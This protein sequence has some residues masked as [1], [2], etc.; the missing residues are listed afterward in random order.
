MKRIMTK[1][2]VPGMVIAE[3]VYSINNNQLI[4]EKGT[5]LSDKAIAK[6]GY[7][8][9]INVFVEDDSQKEGSLHEKESTTL[10]YSQRLR[11]T[12]EFKKFKEDV[13]NA[14][15]H[16]ESEMNQIVFKGA[17]LDP[18]EI[19]KPILSIIDTGSGPSNIFDMLHSLRNYDDATYMHCINVALICNIIGQWLRYSEKDIETLTKAG[20]LHDIGKMLIPGNIITKPAKLT[21]DEYSIVMKHPE[22]G[23]QILKDLD[24]DEHI[25]NGALMHHERRD[26]SGYPSHLRGNEIDSFAGIVSIADVYDAMTSAR[27]YRGSLCPFVAIAL[28]ESDGLT[29]YDPKVLMT[30]MENIVNTYLLNRVRLSNGQE[31]DIVFINRD[32][33][34]RPT[35]RVGDQYIDLSIN[36]EI[37]IDAII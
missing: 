31:G 22:A 29:K 27:V 26:G 7:Y 32:Y 12:K 9:V 11:K 5:V 34:S 28:F 33:L 21:E 10:S 8:T 20:L 6:L 37:T 16:F 25:K 36:P 14:S 4:M 30:F 15:S 1:Q 13:E 23:Y 35:V 18:D 19:V 24:I 2:L 3:N 17:D